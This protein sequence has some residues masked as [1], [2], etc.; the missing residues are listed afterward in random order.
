MREQPAAESNQGDAKAEQGPRVERSGENDTGKGDNAN[1]GAHSRDPMGVGPAGQPAR[2]ERQAGAAAKREHRGERS[3][4]TN[5]EVQD[6]SAVG[7]EQN[8]L[9]AESGGPQRGSD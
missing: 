5:R 3:R 7:L 4:R 8:V 6:F 2:G 9:H 1:E